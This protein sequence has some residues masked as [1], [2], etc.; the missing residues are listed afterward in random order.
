[1]FE[2]QSHKLFNFGNKEL[3]FS[4]HHKK[5]IKVVEPMCVFSLYVIVTWVL[6]SYHKVLFKQNAGFHTTN[7][8]DMVDFGRKKSQRRIRQW[9]KAPCNNWRHGGTAIRVGTDRSI[10]VV[11]PIGC[12]RLV[13]ISR[14]WFLKIFLF[15]P[16][17]GEDSYFDLYFSQGVETTN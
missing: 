11:V 3:S 9:H 10:T 15:S 17:F 14:W 7:A 5:Q 2:H 4:K 1:M 8:S 6:Q 13:Y 16:R 12:M